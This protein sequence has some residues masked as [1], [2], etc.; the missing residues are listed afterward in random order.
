LAPAMRVVQRL[1]EMADAHL[2]RLGA[3]NEILLMILNPFFSKML[4][5][6]ER[7]EMYD[8]PAVVKAPLADTP[9]RRS[10]I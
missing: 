8:C 2:L 5:C 10:P 6:C 4:V 3:L 9:N 1:R 7:T